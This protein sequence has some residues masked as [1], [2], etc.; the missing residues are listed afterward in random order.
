MV[1]QVFWGEQ[2]LNA[3][4]NELNTAVIFSV[5][6]GLSFDKYLVLHPV[7]QSGVNPNLIANLT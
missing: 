1:S 2:G 7:Q 6:V 5:F 4:N 3:L